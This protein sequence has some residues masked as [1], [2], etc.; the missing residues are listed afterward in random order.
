MVISSGSFNPYIDVP[1]GQGQLVVTFRDYC[2][3]HILNG[4]CFGG[5]IPT[6]FAKVGGPV[7]VRDDPAGNPQYDADYSAS[8]LNTPLT[9]RN[10]PLGASRFYFKVGSTLDDI[11][12]AYYTIT[13][14]FTPRP[15]AI[16]AQPQSRT[17]P[18]GSSATFGVSASGES[19]SYQWQRNGVSIGGANAPNYTIFNVQPGDAGSF[20][21]VVS[22]GGGSATSDSATLTVQ[23]PPSI[24]VQP[25]NQIISFTSNTILSVSVSASA[26]FTYQWLFNGSPVA[27]SEQVVFTEDFEGYAPGSN[28]IG[29]GGWSNWPAFLPTSRLVVNSGTH[30]PGNVLDGRSLYDP[31]QLHGGLRGIPVNPEGITVVRLTAFATSAPLRSHNSGLSFGSSPNGSAPSAGWEPVSFTGSAPSTAR[32]KFA[33]TPGSSVEIP[34]GFDAPIHLAVVADGIA[35]R[36]YGIYDFGSGPMETPHYSVSH[37]DI[38]ALQFAGVYVDQHAVTLNATGAEIDNLTVGRAHFS[39][40]RSDRLSIANIQPG[41]AGNYQVI[42][43]NDFGAVTS[44]V[45]VVT[46]PSQSPSISVQPQSLTATAGSNAVLTATVS[47]TAPLTY[48][49]LRNGVPVVASGQTVFTEDFEGYAP[50]SNLIGQGGWSN[51]PAF[52]PTSRLVVN[53]GTHLPGNVLDGRSLYDPRQLH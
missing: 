36:I 38:A 7:V 28:L 4:E 40:T 25:G 8:F 14:T 43:R 19:L 53:S 5:Y 18:I 47:G 30:L 29:Q 32:W 20:R 11:L 34:G 31:R 41:H 33:A 46:V 10:L 51:W 2:A 16:T 42:V 17:V 26:P 22:N 12:V 9:V 24:T 23:T 44:A 21:C 52:L 3:Y 50:G 48:Q 27:G 35:N 49:W 15:P 45:A 1:A 6:L 37:A 13:A 39:G